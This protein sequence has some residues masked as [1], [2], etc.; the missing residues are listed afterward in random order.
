MGLQGTAMTKTDEEG[1]YTLPNLPDGLFAIVARKKGYDF[2]ELEHVRVGE[3]VEEIQLLRLGA[4]EG[5]VTAAGTGSPVASFTIEIRPRGGEERP[6]FDMFMSPRTFEDA[7]GTFL[8][9]NVAAGEYD[10]HLEAKGFAPAREKAAVRPG[11]LVELR[12]VLD[13]GFQVRG[14]VLQEGTEEPIE[15]AR[16]NYSRMNQESEPSTVSRFPRGDTS[17]K[18]DADGVFQLE[19]LADGSYVLSVSHHLHYREGPPVR[20]EL[21]GAEQGELQVVMKEAGGVLGTLRGFPERRNREF[22][23]V[24]AT[25]IKEAGDGGRSKS[26]GAKK[27]TQPSISATSYVAPGGKFNV[28]GLKPGTYQLAL[29]RRTYGGQA[30]DNVEETFPVGEV[31]VKAGEIKAVEFDMPTG[32]GQRRVIGGPAVR[33]GTTRAQ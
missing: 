33:V 15:G 8:Y 27:K 29:T 2:A 25:L 11:E 12:F 14:V 4:I 16:V 21:P 9:E 13:Q 20:F 32:P 1:H 24:T 30:T 19:S 5:V 28:N 7:K 3:T 6:R 18:T 17:V 31:E 10:V 26:K 22:H 23:M